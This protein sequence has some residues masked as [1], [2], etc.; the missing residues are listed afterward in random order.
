MD[1]GRNRFVDD[2]AGRRARSSQPLVLGAARELAPA[3]G[4]SF[5]LQFIHDKLYMQNQTVLLQ[6]FSMSH[7]FNIITINWYARK[8]DRR[9]HGT[10]CRRWRC[11]HTSG[12]ERPRRNRG[13]HR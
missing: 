12:G 8:W 13:W 3:Q 9:L 5:E 4:E 6:A 2:R 10:R 7:G 1:D 11:G